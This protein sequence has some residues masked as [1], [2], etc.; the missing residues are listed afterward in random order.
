MSQ[1]AVI[2]TWF[3]GEQDP[4]PL[5]TLDAQEE[6]CRAYAE[7]QGYDVVEVLRESTSD[8]PNDRPELKRL[9][10]MVW[11]RRADVVIATR[12]DR[13]YLDPNRLTRLAHE[14]RNSG[15]RLEFLEQPFVLQED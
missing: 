10:S 14:A 4:D 1:R 11:G 9:R 15:V 13:L 7:A 3:R 5:D 12:P 6:R 8:E 2:Y